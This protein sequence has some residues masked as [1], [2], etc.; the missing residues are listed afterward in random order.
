MGIVGNLFD[1]HDDDVQEI[2]ELLFR[3]ICYA[4][5]IL[6]FRV[7]RFT[8]RDEIKNKST[9]DLM[10]FDYERLCRFLRTHLR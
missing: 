3:I 10:L 8:G 9:R 1:D 6:L 4:S 7:L 5:S 2:L